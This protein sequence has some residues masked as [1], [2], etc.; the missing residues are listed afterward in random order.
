MYHDERLIKG[1]LHWRGTPDGKWIAFTLEELS[2]RVLEREKKIASAL[3]FI[4][5][6]QEEINP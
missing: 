4:R 3:G 6:I 5:S 2:A 1:I